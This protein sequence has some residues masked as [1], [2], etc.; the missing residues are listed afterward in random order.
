MLRKLPLGTSDYN[1]NETNNKLLELADRDTNDDV[2]TN[3]EDTEQ[4][5]QD[6][7]GPDPSA[8]A[9][10]VT[11]VNT[12]DSRA[13]SSSHNDDID[14]RT[15]WKSKF[16]S[17]LCCLAPATSE[18]LPAEEEGPV[19]IRPPPITELPRWPE[20]VIGPPAAHDI[21]KKTLVLDLD[22]TLVHSSFRPVPSPDY[23]I[24]VE[25]EG[26]IVDVYVLKRPF[27]DHFLRAVGQRFE[28]VVF[29]ASLG[30]YA[31]PLLDLL[32]RS[33]VVRWRLFREA[34][35]P[36]EGSYVKDLQC[37]GREMG[38]LILVD[39][40]PHSYA[41]QPENAIP[42]ETFID[43]MHDQELLECLDLLLAVEKAPDV[44]PALALAM[45]RR[46]AGL[47]YAE[48]ADGDAGLGN[49]GVVIA[50]QVANQMR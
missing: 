30:K 27:V 3:A 7:Q 5:E 41:F 38:Q 35:Y 32:D 16:R 42:I 11:Q 26:R 19:V 44:R 2:A 43:D 50:A 9:S 1:N 36:Y 4:E 21:G 39:N 47:P 25:I 29:T 31:D 28:V 23:V 24:P 15:S 6:A 48:G 37:M 8:I 10:V 12:V 18:Q 14:G 34:C 40:S 49:T 13:G 20:P 33:G 17:I 45:A 46:E 22:E